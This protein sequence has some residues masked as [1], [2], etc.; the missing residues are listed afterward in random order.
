M[1]DVFD[2]LI[3]FVLVIIVLRVLAEIK[4]E[5]KQVDVERVATR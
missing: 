2:L 5:E 4:P 3:V 1:S